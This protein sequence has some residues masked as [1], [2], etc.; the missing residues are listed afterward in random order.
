[1]WV[2]FASYGGKDKF[3]GKLGR[4]SGIFGRE[5]LVVGGFN[6]GSGGTHIL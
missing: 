2:K 5:T 6:F 3:G 4:D 1:M